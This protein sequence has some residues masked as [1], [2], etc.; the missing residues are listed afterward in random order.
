MPKDALSRFAETI[1]KQANDN[2]NQSIEHASK[3]NREKRAAIEAE[4]RQSSKKEL[5]AAVSKI[6]GETAK[7]AAAVESEYRINLLKRRNQICE[8]V[9]AEAKA[10]LA[11]FTGSADYDDYFRRMLSEAFSLIDS[12]DAV[13]TVLERDR[14]L[15]EA[16]GASLTV[17]TTA[18]DIIGGFTL[19]SE[20]RRL[21]CDCTLSAKL[22]EQ[23]DY[24][25]SVSGLNIE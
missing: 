4:I 13:C 2:K 5:Q 19:K 15:A 16:F 7:R 21:F 12:D 25:Y 20:S 24:F 11:E 3:K 18:D 1:I 14:V 22:D 10:R 23:R 6:K 9:F 17:E 8:E